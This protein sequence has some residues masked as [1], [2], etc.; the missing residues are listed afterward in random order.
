V[1]TERTEET[2]LSGLLEVTIG[3]Q[4]VRLRALTIAESDEWLARLAT[5]LADAEV[6]EDGETS[7]DTLRQLV[8]HASASALE[9]VLAYDLDGMLGGTEGIRTRATKRE[10]ADALEMMVTVEDPLGPSTRRLVEAAFGLPAQL[11]ADHLEQINQPMLRLVRSLNTLSERGASTTPGTS[12][13]D[14]P[15]SSSSSTGRTRRTGTGAT[16]K[17]AAS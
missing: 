4:P 12:D 8:T 2:G 10:V 6:M 13:P 11:A 5:A 9:M 16:P 17:S 3:G 1:T 7:A 14:G 15:A